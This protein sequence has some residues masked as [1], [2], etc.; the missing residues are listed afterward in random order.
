MSTLEEVAEAL[1]V[2]EDE[3][4]MREDITVLHCTTDY[5]TSLEDVNL[6]AMLTL[7]HKCGVDVGYSDHTE[8]V[9]IS[10]VAVGMGAKVI[11]KHL[12]LDKTLPGPD[13]RASLNP[14]EFEELTSAIRSV[15]KSLGAG[16]KAPTVAEELNRLVVRKSLVAKKPIAEGD[17]LSKDNLAT[18]RPGSGIS[19]MEWNNFIGR[20]ASRPYAEDDLLDP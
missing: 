14:R 16:V 7:E 5:P 19:P 3:G 9:L 10:P 13:H 18:K 6:K 12:T 20:K 11:E 15:E 1:D 8:G 4:L 2:F 17:I